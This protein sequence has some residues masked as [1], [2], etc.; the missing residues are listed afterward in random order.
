MGAFSVRCSKCN[1]LGHIDR[2]PTGAFAQDQAFGDE[3]P[4]VVKLMS[5]EHED[6]RHREW[7]RFWGSASGLWR[8]LSAWRIWLVCASLVGV[9]ALQ[10]YVQFRLNYWNRDF[11][12]ALESRDP[13]R[14]HAQAILLIPLCG[15]SIALAAMSVWGRMTVQRKWREWLTNNLIDYWI[16]N[17]RYA[18]LARVQGDQ[19]IIPEYRISED[20]RIATDAPIDFALGIVS[21]LLTAVIFVQVLWS[22]GGEASFSVSGYQFW[23]PGYLVGSVAVYSGIV[24]IAMVLVGSPLTSVIQIKNQAEAELIT[25]AHLLRDI[26]EGVMPKLQE[27]EARRGLQQAL[28]NVLARWRRLC[29]QLVRNTLVSQGNTLLA[30]VVGL[31]LCSPKFLAGT[32]T[33]GELTQAAAAFTLV[34]SSFNWLVDNYGRLADWVSSLERVGRLLLALDELDRGIVPTARE[35]TPILGGSI[36][37]LR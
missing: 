19:K 25:A 13:L 28:R 7:R 14:L 21:S 3:R 10:L 4:L 1:P 20:V 27:A 30:P 15:A 12:N 34:Q 11:F 2:P 32:M 24:T 16:E 6:N 9:V 23:I 35:E 5:E 17:D 31:V 26:G 33:L 18:G 8:D 36:T 37:P 22:V 29:W